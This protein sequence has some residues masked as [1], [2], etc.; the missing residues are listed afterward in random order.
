MLTSPAAARF[1]S[2]AALCLVASLATPLAER[3]DKPQVVLTAAPTVAFTPAKVRFVVD[4]RGGADDYEEFYC[5]AV[6]W[7]WDDGT[8]SE[9]AADCDPY[10]A[11]TSTIRRHF[12]A[13]H[14]YDL[15]G[16]YRP[17]FSLKKRNKV[18]GHAKANIEVRSGM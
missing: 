15:A 2:C 12:T 4:L 6:V 14:T 3:S 5:A 10:Q 16:N 8:T 9:A 1:L 13:E 18:V 7:D 11:G 17:T